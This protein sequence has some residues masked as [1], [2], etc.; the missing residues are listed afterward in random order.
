[1]EEGGDALALGWV[2]HGTWES[3]VPRVMGSLTHLFEDGGA[4]Y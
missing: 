1:M 2:G 3:K 4:L